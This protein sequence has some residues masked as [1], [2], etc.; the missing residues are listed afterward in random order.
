MRKLGWHA[1]QGP[2]TARERWKPVQYQLN[3]SLLPTRLANYRHLGFEPFVAS[4][5]QTPLH[6][7]VK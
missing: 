4:L 6:L 2:P 7:I 1:S 3:A 5:V